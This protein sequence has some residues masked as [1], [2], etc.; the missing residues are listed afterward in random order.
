VKQEAWVKNKFDKVFA[1]KSRFKRADV[2]MLIAEYTPPINTEVNT[3]KGNI[4]N[5]PTINTPE[6]PK[7]TVKKTWSALNGSDT[8]LG[9]KSP[10][11]AHKN[12]QSLATT[13]LIR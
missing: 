10:T 5:T 13:P 12:L 3:V 4:K 8:P 6:E 11:S 7:N 2:T 1:R 9:C